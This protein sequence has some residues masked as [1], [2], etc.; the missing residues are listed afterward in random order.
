MGTNDTTA[1]AATAG[2]AIG[3]IVAWGLSLIPGVDVPVEV[4]GGFATI[5]AFLFGRWFP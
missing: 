5:G 3:G 1:T 2:A 4:G